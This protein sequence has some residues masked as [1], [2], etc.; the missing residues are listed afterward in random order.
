MSVQ[1]IADEVGL[2]DM[3]VYRLVKSKK[4]KAY[5]VGNQIRVRREDFYKYL[6][7]CEVR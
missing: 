3:T 5:R 1:D 2:H 7:T 4:L 6:E